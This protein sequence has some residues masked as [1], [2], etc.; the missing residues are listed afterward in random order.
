MDRISDSDSEDAG[1]IPA[2][3]TKFYAYVIRS[4]KFGYV[5]KGHCQDLVARLKQHNAGMTL[6][7]RKYIPFEVVYVEELESKTDAIRREKYL[8]SAAGRKFLK[9]KIG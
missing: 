6:S 1:S 3:A 8:K 2:G 9:S 7:I 4:I 5:Y